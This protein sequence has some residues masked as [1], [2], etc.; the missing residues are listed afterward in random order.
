MLDRNQSSAPQHD[1]WNKGRL[2][3]QKRP[4][5]PKDVWSIRVRLQLEHR[6]RDLALFN[7]AIDSKLR[8]CD[9]VRL[10]VDDVCAGG[11]VRD[12]A[13]VIQKKT[14][15][16]V[17][18]EITEQTRTAIQAW[19]PEVAGRNGRATC[20]RA[21]S[22]HRRTCRRGN[23]RGSFMLGS[24]APAWMAR[25]TARTRCAGRRRHRSIRRRAIFERSS[26]FLGIRSWRAPSVTSASKWM[27]RS[28]FPNRSSCKSVTG[29]DPR[30]NR[31]GPQPQPVHAVWGSPA[32][33]SRW[34]D[35]DGAAGLG[36]TLLF[37]SA[38]RSR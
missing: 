15:R 18:F 13:T 26:C 36:A 33:C 30:P 17:Q 37:A 9:L 32:D 38:F 16:P 25:P 1:P 24:R 19:L 3:G 21:A 35:D 31:R 11:R 29:C 23:T 2:I 5:K 6:A 7:L 4:L 10:Q 12:R 8:G 27:T 22:G 28:P 14:G 34:C 20:S